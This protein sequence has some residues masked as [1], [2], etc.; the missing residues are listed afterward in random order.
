MIRLY[1]TF[2]AVLLGSCSLVSCSSHIDRN[3]SGATASVSTTAPEEYAIDNDEIR[4]PLADVIGDLHAGAAVFVNR[5]EGHCVL[6]HKV[7]S[8]A[9]PFQGNLGPDLSS[10]GDRLTP[11]QIRFRIVDA[12]KLNPAT[13]MPPYY[14]TKNLHQQTK[15]TAGKPVLSANDVEQL[16]YY[17][18]SLQERSL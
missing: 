5:E 3:I 13:I 1:T 17:L 2:V 6:C 18:S 14:R 9:A 10:V 8:L 12:S 4:L 16:V 7:S 15:A 11:A